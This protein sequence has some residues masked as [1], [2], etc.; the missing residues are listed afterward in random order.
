MVIKTFS[1]VANIQSNFAK[2]LR[3][4]P[5][6]V[7]GASPE[8]VAF[9][10]TGELESFESKM[11]KLLLSS[12][13][14]SDEI[15]QAAGDAIVTFDRETLEIDVFNASAER[16]FGYFASELKT[17]Q[18]KITEILP[19]KVLKR[20]V[21]GGDGDRYS[22]SN[23]DD[24][25]NSSSSSSTS[26]PS[27]NGRTGTNE[28]SFVIHQD[29]SKIPVL[30]SSSQTIAGISMQYVLFIRDVR[31]IRGYQELLLNNDRLLAKMLPRSIATKLKKNIMMN[32]AEH[33]SFAQKHESVS[34]LFADIDRFTEMTE[35]MPAQKIANI[36]NSIVT[37]WDKVLMVHGVE[38]IKTIGDVYMA[39]SGCPDSVVMPSTWWKHS[40]KKSHSK[41]KVKED[42]TE[43]STTAIKEEATATTKETP[44]TNKSNQKKKQTPSTDLL[45]NHAT[46]LV[47][48]AASM[49]RTIQ[50][51]NRASGLNMRVRVGI[52]SG[53]VVAGVIG[54]SKVMFDIWGSSVNV[55]SR[56]ESSGIVD[57]IQITKNTFDL[58]PIGMFPFFPRGE[59][60]VKGGIRFSTYLYSP[61]NPSDASSM[62]MTTQQSMQPS[63]LK[64]S[65]IS[66]LNKSSNSTMSH[67]SRVSNVSSLHSSLGSENKKVT[68]T[69]VVKLKRGNKEQMKSVSH[70]L[71]MKSKI[72][73][74][75][76]S[77]SG[78]ESDQSESETTTEKN[79]KDKNE[80]L[81]ESDSETSYSENDQRSDDY[82][83][84]D[85]NNETNDE[86]MEKEK[87]KDK[88]EQ[89]RK[90]TELEK[91]AKELTELKVRVAEME[92]KQQI[93]REKMEKKELKEKEEKEEKEREKLKKEREERKRKQKEEKEKER[94]E[95]EKAIAEREQEE[96]EE[97]EQ[98]T[99]QMKEEQIKKKE[100]AWCESD[101]EH[102]DDEEKQRKRS[103]R[104]KH[105]ITRQ[106][107]DEQVIV[108]KSIEGVQH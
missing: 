23:D 95:K 73:S 41:M 98:R 55:A 69:Q 44:P 27:S 52:N 97:E 4:F 84:D 77:E 57:M 64:L 15:L 80:T 48:C 40:E 79:Q 3:C 99:K 104:K 38:K 66:N 36:L 50:E 100:K 39:V 60:E 61:L 85:D 87:Q 7:Y 49:I 54:R 11:S 92:K 93:E 86:E 72:E 70:G 25:N 108:L 68:T 26:T 31:D 14:K 33:I 78:N 81:G 83:D 19:M 62:A 74:G 58:L 90:E 96:R 46:V 34:I 28:S 103:L 101:G 5:L 8:I 105:P 37:A 16:M 13:Q 6:S 10:T 9:I 89:K 30:I 43:T 53:A 63:P 18:A 88:E 42:E 35:D 71:K 1:T 24:Q 76:E 75:S 94:K 20:H 106:S 82:R 47:E 91:Q 107:G 22:H 65:Q 2:I 45:Y 67:V 56:M 59:I 17:R 21:L 102:E 51:F 29:G 12:Q 32:G